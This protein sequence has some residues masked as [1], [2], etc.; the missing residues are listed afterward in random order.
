MTY[1][2]ALLGIFGIGFV[3]LFLAGIISAAR[4]IRS[5]KRAGLPV[6]RPAWDVEA[7]AQRRSA[8]QA[9]L[10]TLAPWAFRGRS[11]GR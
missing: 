5:E 9:R 8:R 6:T 2:L 1:F 4:E 11:H 10:T 7:R 3:V